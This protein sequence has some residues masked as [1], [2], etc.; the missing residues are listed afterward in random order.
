MRA[1]AMRRIPL[2]SISWQSDKSNVSTRGRILPVPELSIGDGQQG[3]RD[4]D[5]VRI[6]LGV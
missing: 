2:I 1:Y 3:D 5:F 6:V 4:A